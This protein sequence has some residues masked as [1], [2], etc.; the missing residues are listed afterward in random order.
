MKFLSF[1][2]LFFHGITYSQYAGIDYLKIDNNNASLEY[3]L[4]KYIQIPSV[5]GEEKFAGDYIKSICKENGLVISSFGEEN[6]NYNFAASIFPLSSQ[7]P[8]I[9][10]LNH[11]DVVPESEN[12]Q[13]KPFSGEILN[14]EVFGRGAVDN[15]GAAVMQLASILNVLKNGNIKNSKYNITFLAVSCEETQ[16]SGGVNYVI[17]NYLQELNPVVVIGEGPTELTSLIG[18]NFNNPIFGVS[19]AHKRSFWLNL[20]REMYTMGHGSVTPLQYANKEM[21]EALD[22]LVTK[23]QKAVF[24]DINTGI[25][26][27]MASH[28]KGLEKFIMGHPRFFKPV[29]I[30]QLRKQPELFAI[31]SNTITLTNIN[32]NNNAY[33]IIPSNVEAFLDCRLLPEMDEYEFIKHIQK[34]IKN[35]SIKITV[36]ENMPKAKPSSTKNI[37]YQNMIK[38][39]QLNYPNSQVAPIMMPNINDLGAFRTKG[40]TAFATIPVYLK[41]EHIEG[42]H[43]KDE[44]IPIEALYNG[45]QVYFDFL[46]LMIE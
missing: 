12:S 46:Q 23:K 32:S 37:F 44:K 24:N 30:P 25:L 15:K 22:R 8:N 41:R 11:I 27:T 42:I 6:G 26:K 14:G 21:V 39:I 9:V 1:L 28:K 2:I 18:G 34:I 35:D 36:I 17:E 43:N 13:T 31:F 20:K 16:C 45:A 10:L 19:V 4:Q 7:K 33:N 40:I 29:L 5:S 38:A 3:L